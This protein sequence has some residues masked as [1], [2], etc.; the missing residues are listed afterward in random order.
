MIRRFKA[1]FAAYNFFQ[2][3]ELAHNVPLYKKLGLK[4]RYFSPI[5]SKDFEQINPALIEASPYQELAKT[6]FF[7]KLKPASQESVLDF[8]DNGY[9]I[10]KN[11][12]SENEVDAINEN[13][14]DLLAKKTIAYNEVQKIM[15]AFHQSNLLKELG[16]NKDFLAFLS[17]LLKGKANLFQSINF[18]KGSQQKTHSDS[19]HMTTFP[20]GGLLGVWI[21]LEDIDEENGPLHYYKGSHK[22]PYYLNKDYDNE[23]SFFLTGNKTYKAYEAMI[24]GEIEKQQLQKETFLAKKGDMLIWHANLLHGGNAQTD[25]NR[26]RKSMVFHYY[27]TDCICY[28]EITQRPALLKV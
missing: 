26:T 21:A 18:L 28:H 22:L 24:G 1:A 3:K 14:E 2:K 10:I 13:I 27:N 9:S 15:F 23:G 17:A 20:L 8:H 19:I 12:L 16:Q 25:P 6:A 4:K 11:F 7:K 5:S